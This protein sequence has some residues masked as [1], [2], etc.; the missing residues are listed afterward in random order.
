MASLQKRNKF[1]NIVF[2]KRVNGKDF[3]KKFSLNTS[4]KRLAER[5][6]IEYE[7]LFSEGE[8]DPFGGWSPKTHEKGVQFIT[9]H[10]QKITPKNLVRLI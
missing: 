3:Q 9:T 4:K 5:K 10:I 7:Q 2:N 6:K 8:I 1:Y